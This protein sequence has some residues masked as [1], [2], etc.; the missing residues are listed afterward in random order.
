MPIFVIVRLYY[1]CCKPKEIFA[2]ENSFHKKFIFYQNHFFF[3][4]IKMG[5]SG[6]FEHYWSISLTRL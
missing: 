6:H 4:F 1:I 5:L 2:K 3:L